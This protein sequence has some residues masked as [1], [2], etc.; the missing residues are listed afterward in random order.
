[1]ELCLR[2]R[3]PL[4]D[5]EVLRALCWKKLRTLE[6]NVQL[7]AEADESLLASYD[8]VIIS[9]YSAINALLND[10]PEVQRKY[11]FELCEKPVVRLPGE[12]SGKSIVVLDGPFMCLDPFGSTGLF[13]LGN[14]VHAIHETNIG[15]APIIDRSFKNLINQG[16]IK[17]PPV[18]KFSHFISAGTKFFPGIVRA[19]HIGSMFTIRTVLPYR[20]D[21]DERPTIVR[22]VTNRIITIF[23]GKIGTCVQA[24]EKVVAFIAMDSAEAKES[25]RLEIS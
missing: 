7:N 4:F 23:S 15:Y 13:V 11:Q 20:E 16:V 8:Y 6:V 1:M 12:F 21:T 19:E 18:T 24:A 2:V 25:K 5:P 14:V 3:E 10:V 17:N 22:R 9:T